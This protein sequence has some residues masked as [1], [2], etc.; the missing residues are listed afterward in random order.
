MMGLEIY[1]ADFATRYE[2]SHAISISMSIYY[3]DI[4][5]LTIYAPVNDYNINALKV[6]NIIYDTARQETYIIVNI[7]ID[8]DANQ[9]VVNGYTA[10]SL[11]NNRCI[12]SEFALTTLESGVYQLI[13]DNLR[14][15]P[16]VSCASAEGLTESTDVTLIG[17]QLFDEVQP[18]L[19]EAG[20]GNKM[21]WDPDTL[22]WTFKIYKGQDLTSG[23][24]AV[25]FSEEM[26]TAKELVINDDDSTFKNIAYVT[27]S[28]KNDTEFTEVVGTVEPGD[29]RREVWLDTSVSQESDETEEECKAR[30]IAYATMEL[31]KRLHR[32]SFKVTIDASDLGTIYNIGDIV[33]C[34]SVRFGVSFAARITGVKF[35]MDS[36][37]TRTEI[38][39]GDPILTAL[40]VYKI[41]GKY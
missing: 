5:K 29:D 10:N 4:G 37:S 6:R 33:S 20:L 27:G 19:E 2:L 30:A 13:N 34:V 40:G 12:A 15:L 11:L 36:R 22:S 41:N 9:I 3:N 8:T 39:L 31:G 14:G 38:I 32:Q 24:H 25:V 26:G 1:P 16:R 7:K 28:L 17:G 21:I 35:E 23:I 18:Y